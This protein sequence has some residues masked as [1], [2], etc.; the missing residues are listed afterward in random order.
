MAV[1]RRGIC[2]LAAAGVVAAC[3]DFPSDAVVPDAGVYDGPEL[4]K[5]LAPIHDGYW[6][7]DGA[8]GSHDTWSVWPDTYPPDQRPPGPTPTSNSGQLCTS[9]C[10]NSGEECLSFGTSSSGM[11]LGK[12]SNPGD[13]CPVANSA[14]QMSVCAV[15]DP[16]QTQYYCVFFC[17][18]QGQTFSCPDP[19]NN[20]CAVMDPSQPSLKL[21]MPK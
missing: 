20:T 10:P 13:P 3:V 4:T 7:P 5:L 2:V 16:T 6:A 15:S 8:G 1:F 12:C 9:T 14:T 18:I 21:C 19:A 17:E 11:C